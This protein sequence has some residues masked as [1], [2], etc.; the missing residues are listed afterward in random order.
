MACEIGPFALRVIYIKMDFYC[1][2]MDV[3]ITYAETKT[4][5]T[6]VIETMCE[7]SRVKR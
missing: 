1:L 3:K 6:C 2:V 7:K 5:F 4:G